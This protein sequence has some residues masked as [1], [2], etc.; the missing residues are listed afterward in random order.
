MMEK[1]DMDFLN[2]NLEDERKLIEEIDA[3][4]VGLMELDAGSIFSA[5]DVQAEMKKLEGYLRQPGS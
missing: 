4:C 5:N 2:A 3:L 1:S